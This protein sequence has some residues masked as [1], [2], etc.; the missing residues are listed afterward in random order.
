MSV[1]E[2]KYCPRCKQGFECNP[3]DITNCDCYGIGFSDDHRKW[4]AGRFEDCI[5]HH[6]LLALRNEIA[7][8]PKGLPLQKNENGC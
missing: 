6:C 1:A 8:E 3:S 5:C 4:I 7:L 2:L